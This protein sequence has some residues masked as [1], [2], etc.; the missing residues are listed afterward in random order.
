MSRHRLE[1]SEFSFAYLKYTR[2]FAAQIDYNKNK[3]LPQPGYIA[4]V[5]SKIFETI[6]SRYNPK[7]TSDAESET[8]LRTS[9]LGFI[10]RNKPTPF[11]V[12]QRLCSNSAPNA[13]YTK[14]RTRLH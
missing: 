7:S 5:H 6:I 11:K 8:S 13:V 14:T 2:L 4:E 12:E 1:D 9:I 10:H 3:N